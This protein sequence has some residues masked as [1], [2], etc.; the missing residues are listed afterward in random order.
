MER[1]KYEEVLWDFRKKEALEQ[2]TLITDEQFGGLSR[3]EFV[4]NPGGQAVFKGNIST[5]LPPA[6]SVKYSGMCSIRAQPTWDWKGD[7]EA[8]DITDYDGIVM[9]VRG[10]GRTYALNVQTKSVRDDDIHQSFFHTRGGPLWDIVKVPFTKFVLTNAGFL[11]DQQM[12]FPRIR[13]LGFTLADWNTGP[14][15]LEIDYIKVVLFMYQP[16]FFSYHYLSKV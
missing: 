16:K 14:F 7:V 12:A 10:D 5:E 8:N 11:Q 6:S 1:L 2:W 13:T 9:R 15:H 3:A 4:Q